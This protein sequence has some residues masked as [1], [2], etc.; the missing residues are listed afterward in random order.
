MEE[1]FD[2]IRAKM[3]FAQTVIVENAD[4]YRIFISHFKFGD[5]IWLSA[6]DLKIRRPFKKVRLKELRSF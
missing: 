6:R 4:K 5:K 3:K 1:I 2:Y